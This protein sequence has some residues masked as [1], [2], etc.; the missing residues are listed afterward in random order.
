ME[1]SREDI[2]AP[3]KFRTKLTFV[4]PLSSDSSVNAP[5]R[6]HYDPEEIKGL[7]NIV[8]L[9]VDSYSIVSLAKRIFLRMFGLDVWNHNGEMAC[10][11]RTSMAKDPF[12]FWSS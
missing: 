7:V 3:K 10:P 6:I 12:Y 4:L 9:E 2:D 11:V 5:A 1:E 8:S